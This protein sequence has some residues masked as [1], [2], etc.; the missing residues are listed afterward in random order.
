M[1]SKTKRVALITC[2]VIAFTF[3]SKS[4]IVLY[5]LS[6]VFCYCQSRHR[7]SFAPTLQ[8]AIE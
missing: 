1:T 7:N 6:H 3:F 2:A 5:A 8:K 4:L